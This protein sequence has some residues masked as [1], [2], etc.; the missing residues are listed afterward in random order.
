MN[1][2]ARNLMDKDPRLIPTSHTATALRLDAGGNPVVNC[3]ICNMTATAREFFASHLSAHR[4][5]GKVLSSAQVRAVGGSICPGESTRSATTLGTRK[6]RAPTN[7]PQSARKRAVTYERAAPMGATRRN[8]ESSFDE[9]QQAN[10]TAVGGAQTEEQESPTQQPRTGQSKQSHVLLEVQCGMNCG[11]GLPGPWHPITLETVALLPKPAKVKVARLRM[12]FSKAV[13]RITALIEKAPALD[14]GL[15]RLM[16]VM[17]KL[18]LARKGG[19]KTWVR[20]AVKACEAFPNVSAKFVQQVVE[21]AAIHKERRMQANRHQPNEQDHDWQAEQCIA[22]CKAVL[23]KT[24]SITKAL[25]SLLSSGI[26][27]G[28]DDVMQQLRDLHPPQRHGDELGAFVKKHRAHK[29]L[30]EV[31]PEHI[32][33][34]LLEYDPTAASGIDGWDISLMREAFGV[35]SKSTLKARADAGMDPWE[36]SPQLLLLT[37]I[38]AAIT[39][40]KYPDRAWI[41]AASLLPLR[42]KVHAVRPIA[43]GT[44]W[45]RLASSVTMQLCRPEDALDSCQYGVGTGAEVLVHKIRGILSSGDAQSGACWDGKNAFNNLSRLAMLREVR[46]RCP[47]FYRFIAW[48]YGGEP[49]PLLTATEAGDMQVILSQEGPQQGDNCGSLLQSLV[50]TPHLLKLKEAFPRITVS[51]YVDDISTLSPDENAKEDWDAIRDHMSSQEWTADGLLYGDN[52]KDS[53]FTRASIETDP[54]EFL[55]SFL[56][57]EVAVGEKLV[58]ELDKLLPIRQKILRLPKHTALVVIRKCYLPLIQYWVRTIPPGATAA[59]AEVFDHWIVQLLGALTGC[60]ELPASALAVA[61]LPLREGG[62]GLL[63]QQQ[64]A[65]IAYAAAYVQAWGTIGMR[66]AADPERHHDGSHGGDLYHCGRAHAVR[67]Y[68]LHRLADLLELEGVHKL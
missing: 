9:C 41:L 38:V 39:Q 4:V 55:G 7:A 35:C 57:G 11:E 66:A 31:K 51:A 34:F 37:R 16:L 22:R 6:R 63:P 58:S 49:T 52:G 28:T 20:A 48:R 40:G 26:H 42:K 67:E 14:R 3:P 8:L 29:C 59:A 33:E 61:H 65:P 17:P 46:Q 21:S 23:A 64:L 30:L 10:A 15:L 18:L 1:T 24:G 60:C 50:M 36:P 54:V 68:H 32:Q 56:G 53:D 43:C 62:L 13:G 5:E 2:P 47:Q 44:M 12:A 27:K 19:R 25:R 45:A